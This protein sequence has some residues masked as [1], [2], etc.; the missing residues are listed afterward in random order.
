MS[1]PSERLTAVIAGARAALARR[2]VRFVAAIAVAGGVAI[3]ALHSRAQLGQLRSIGR[4]DPVWLAAAI[5]AELTSILAYVLVVRELLRLGGA[6]AP[7]RSLLRPTLAGVAMGVT[8]PAGVAPANAYWFAQ[9]RRHGADRRQAALA[10]SGSSAAGALSL[11][12]LLVAGVALAGD[13]GPFAHA[14]IWVLC[15]AAA[16]LAARFALA[17]PLG[18]VLTRLLRRVVPTLEAR[19]AVRARRVRTIM[20]LA[21]A[22][23]LLD[24]A[25]LYAS[26]AAVHASVPARG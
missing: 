10:L 6:K 23:W 21:H 19:D 8:L 17:R 26:L 13:A 20:V 15:V 2:E 16:L 5:A 14:Y 7:V 4:P 22:N 11:A 9:L 24:C 3:V 1:V 25:A 18:R 12:G